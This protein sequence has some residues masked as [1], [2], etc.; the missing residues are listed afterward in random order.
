MILIISSPEDVHAVAV[1]KAL[2]ARDAK[3]RILDLSEFPMSMDIGLSFATGGDSQFTL[4]F[5]DG[6]RLDFAS[7]KAVWWRRPQAFGFPPGMSD[8]VNRA[9]AQQESDFAFKGMYLS[10]GAYWINDITRDAL[11]SHKPWQLHIARSLGF[12]IP[13]TLI[14]NNPDA[15]RRF[16]AE[17]KGPVVYKAFLASPM[18]WRETRVPER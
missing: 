16:K 12:S 7:V 11:A 9:F 2:N 10:S 15:A 14:T 3:N 5:K 17:S 8:P 6:E 13:R 4:R 1:Q 18:A